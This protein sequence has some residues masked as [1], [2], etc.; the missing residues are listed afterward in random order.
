MQHK[1]HTVSPDTE[2]STVAQMMRTHHI[3]RVF[4]VDE[5]D[6]LVGVVTANDL[7]YLLEDSE[8]LKGVLEATENTFSQDTQS[9]TLL[10]D[11]VCCPCGTYLKDGSCYFVE[12]LYSD[13]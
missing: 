13:M 2:V 5:K 12:A 7:L 11:E 4:V 1:V 3:H 10:S 8:W 6:E 9:A